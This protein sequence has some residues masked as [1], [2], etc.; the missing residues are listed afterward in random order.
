ML[1]VT[2]KGQSAFEDGCTRLKSRK[3]KSYLLFSLPKTEECVN[4]KN[5]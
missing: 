2:E 5:I 3:Q 1:F 4:A